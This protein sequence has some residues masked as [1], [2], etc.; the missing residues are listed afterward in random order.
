[1]GNE[2]MDPKGVC[3]T[4]RK[5]DSNTSRT[6]GN[7]AGPGLSAEFTNREHE[8]KGPTTIPAEARLT[9]TLQTPAD[10]LDEKFDFIH[11]WGFIVK[12][13]KPQGCIKIA[14]ML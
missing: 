2:Y 11:I 12:G 3:C 1:M 10:N 9:Y 7:E 14:I 8:E 5:R 6:E 4:N 13:P